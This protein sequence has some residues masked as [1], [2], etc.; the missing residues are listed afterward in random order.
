[1][2]LFH[3]WDEFVP[4]CWGATEKEGNKD[5]RQGTVM[6]LKNVTMEGDEFRSLLEWRYS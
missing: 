5:M 2:L 6:S 3:S 1:M 4:Q